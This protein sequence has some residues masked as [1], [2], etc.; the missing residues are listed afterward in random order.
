MLRAKISTL[1]DAYRS[2]KANFPLE[3]LFSV[4]MFVETLFATYLWIHSSKPVKTILSASIENVHARNTESNGEHL[5]FFEACLN[6][7]ADDAIEVG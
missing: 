4:Q 2:Q 3:N 7:K 6:R 1:A 5:Q